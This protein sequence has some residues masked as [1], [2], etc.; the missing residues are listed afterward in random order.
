MIVKDVILAIIVVF[1]GNG[2]IV[3]SPANSPKAK[4]LDQQKI[5][6]MTYANDELQQRGR[7]FN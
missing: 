3:K 6:D 2:K 7:L 5:S 1:H 4:R